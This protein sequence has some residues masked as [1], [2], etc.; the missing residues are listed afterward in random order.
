MRILLACQHR[1]PASGETGSGLHPK[2][3]PSGSAYHLHDLLAQGLAELGHDVFY[4]LQQGAEIPLPRGVRLV[5]G[6]VPDVDIYH[7]PAGPPEYSDEIKQLAGRH[8]T[9][10]LL[11]C[12]ML[13][14]G[15]PA[16]SNWVFVS[17]SLAQAHGSERVVVNGINPSD[18]TFSEAKQDY[19]LFMGAM[20]KAI[21]KG[22]DLALSLSR[23]KGFRLIVAG[24]GLDYDTIRYVSGL[25]AAPTTGAMCAASKKRS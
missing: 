6:P 21:D 12:H 4:L 19:L 20:N 11:T 3:F 10:C 17:R 5:C 23:S 24:T 9:P 13:R 18:Y 25:C 16:S 1:Y 8:R 2:E 14:A 22:L 7:A 15:I